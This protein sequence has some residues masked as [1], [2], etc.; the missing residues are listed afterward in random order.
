LKVKKLIIDTQGGVEDIVAL[1]YAIK[2][3]Q[4]KNIEIVGIT[5]TNGRRTVEAAATD[6]LIAVVATDSDIPI[7]KGNFLLYS[8]GA[9][10]SMMMNQKYP[11]CINYVNN[12]G[13]L[14]F[15]VKTF[16][17][18]QKLKIQSIPAAKFIT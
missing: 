2:A 15:T 13:P 8:K 1:V 18:N 3:A 4:Q 7:Y 10:Q 14:D 12:F 9:T 11:E 16:N 6:A 17:K 5:C